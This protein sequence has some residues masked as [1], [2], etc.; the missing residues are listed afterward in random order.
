MIVVE[1]IDWHRHWWYEFG[2]AV[3]FADSMSDAVVVVDGQYRM[4]LRCP[5]CLFNEKLLKRGLCFEDA[6]W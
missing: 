5:S 1:R 2:A 4:K 3:V 6:V